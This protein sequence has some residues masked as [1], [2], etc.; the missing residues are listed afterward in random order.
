M[1]AILVTILAAFASSLVAKLLLGAGLAFV[2][3]TFIN[4]MVSAAQ[5]EMMGLYGN[6]PS[7]IIG[8]LGLL[9][10]P[11]ALSVLMSAIGTA[12]FIKSS[13]LALGKG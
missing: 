4:D 5:A 1:P 2:S 8:V 9:K 13:K 7:N 6:L 11:Q 10:I 3:Y 12:A